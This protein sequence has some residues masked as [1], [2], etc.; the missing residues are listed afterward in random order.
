M[1]IIRFDKFSIQERVSTVGTKV[2]RLSTSVNLPILDVVIDNQGT[3]Y[4]GNDGRKLIKGRVQRSSDGTIL[5]ILGT[6][7]NYYPAGIEKNGKLVSINKREEEN[8]NV[9]ALSEKNTPLP[10]PKEFRK[11]KKFNLLNGYWCISVGDNEYFDYFD[12]IPIMGTGWVNIKVDMEIVK[13]VRRYSSDIGQKLG[14][15]LEFISKLKEFQNISDINRKKSVGEIGRLGRRRI[16]KEMAAIILLH[17]INEIK[18]FFTP[19][20]SGFLFESFLAGLIPNARIN[21]NNTSADLI[22]DGRTYQV[23]LLS[24]NTLYVDVVLNRTIDPNTKKITGEKYL[25][26][27][28][29]SLKYVDKI[30]VYIIDA[31]TSSAENIGPMDELMTQAG[32]FIMSKIKEK[33]VIEDSIVRKFKIDLTDIEGRILNIGEN[34]KKNLDSLYDE[35]SDFQYNL[36]TI[37]SGIDK[38]GNRMK[39]KGF[40]L[41]DQKTKKNIA[42]LRDSL[43]LLVGDFRKLRN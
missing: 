16:Q 18:D 27:Y 43:E 28:I 2:K 15:H 29:I 23:K 8:G 32:T 41:Y 39:D 24:E 1:N 10:I 26:Y 36:E 22:A 37:I 9:I 6:D 13:R 40:D 20:S 17:Y 7:N 30:E 5:K 34:I 14:G 42:S 38:D 33:A 25:D 3:L 12:L 21:D 31:T 19:S 4:D 35:I 11:N